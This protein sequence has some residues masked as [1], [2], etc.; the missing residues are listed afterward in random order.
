MYLCVLFQFLCLLIFSQGN[1]SFKEKPE[2]ML[3]SAILKLSDW[4][5]CVQLRLQPCNCLLEGNSHSIACISL[6]SLFFITIGESTADQIMLYMLIVN[7]YVCKFEAQINIIFSPVW[8]RIYECWIKMCLFLGRN[9][10]V[11]LSFR[12]L[13]F[14]AFYGNE[15]KRGKTLVIIVISNSL[16]C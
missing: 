12:S 10:T 4:T 1:T 9:E 7:S 2:I 8:P 16:R 14:S 6:E 5:W 3:S 13:C 15:K 11:G